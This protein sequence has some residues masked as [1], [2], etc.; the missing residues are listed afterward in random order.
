MKTKVFA[1]SLI[2]EIDEISTRTTGESET[3]GFCQLFDLRNGQAILFSGD[4]DKYKDSVVF[5]TFDG[6]PTAGSET[7]NKLYKT[8]RDAY[9]S[10][11][12]PAKLDLQTTI[13]EEA[14]SNNEVE[15]LI[16]TLLLSFRGLYNNFEGEVVEVRDEQKSLM[17]ML[18]ANNRTVR[19][20][21]S[22]TVI[23]ADQII[24]SK[25]IEKEKG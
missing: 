3:D 4:F 11:P 6:A 16:M 24:F 22:F 18:L 21:D 25:K 1:D 8:V 9:E 17:K 10:Q 19:M 23:Y 15:H 5:A 20:I 7:Y 12:V 2:L 13:P 14:K